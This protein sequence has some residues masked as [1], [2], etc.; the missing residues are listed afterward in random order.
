MAISTFEIT[1]MVLLGIGLI[2]AIWWF[3]VAKNY[4]KY[5]STYSYARGANVDSDGG[6]VQLK[7]GAGKEICVYRATQICS[8]PSATNFENQA[9][10]PIDA[11]TG[12]GGGNV[13]YGQYNPLTTIDRTA[14]MVDE[15]NGAGSYLYTF[16]AKPFPNGMACGGKTQ[17]LAT[18][19]CISPH[20]ACQSYTAKT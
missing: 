4:E 14:D 1:F 16:N 5:L 7:C 6:Q 15:C 11:G 3:A 19:S 8:N 18:Y 13:D 2:I 9:T 17:L 12:I 10:D 20:T